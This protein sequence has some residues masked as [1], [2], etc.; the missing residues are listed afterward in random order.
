LNQRYLILDYET[1]S[2]ADLK[3]V[4]A[5]EYS[6]HPST[7]ILCAAW[8]IGTRE[9]LKN[10]LI[11]SWAPTRNPSGL[12]SL[13]H[14]LVNPEINLVAHN[15]LFEQVITRNVLRKYSPISIQINK[16]TP[17]NIPSER[18]ICT[19]AMA[20]AMALP[21][22]L[23]G[24]CQALNLP[25]QK[26]MEGRRLILKMCKPRK[27]TK[28][29]S[30]K[31]HESEEDL[32]RIIEYCKT[33]VEAETELFLAVPQLNPTERK[34]W[35]LDQKINLRGFQVDRKLINATLQMIEE[36]TKKLNKET[37]AMSFG[38]LGSTTQR[39]E[40]LKWLEA[41]KV[42][43][44][45]LR[46]K[47]VKDA[48]KTGLADGDAKRM[49]QIRQAVSKT[50]TAKYTAFEMRSR[51]DSRVR[52]ILV[53]HAATTGRWGGAGVQPQNFPRGNIKNTTQAAEILR[54]GDLELIRLLY[55][56]P[57]SAFSSCLRSVIKAPEG[58]EFFCADYNAIEA[59]VLFWV[60]KHAA[61]LKAFRDNRDL[62][63]EM[64]AVIHD[65]E[66]DE[67]NDLERFV[68][69]GVI[70]GCGYGMGWK[71]FVQTCASQGQI[72]QD[73]IAQKAIS[74]YRKVH[75]PVP[76][77]WSNLEKAA[78]AAV[79]NR[80]KKYTINRTSW[81][82]EGKFLFCELPSKRR[83]SYYGPEVR[84]VPTPW[85]E[86]RPVLYH[87]SVNS[88]TRKWELGKTWG[89]V[90]TENVVQ[91]IAR[92]LMA[93]AMLRIEDSGY[94]ISLSVHDELLAER[95]KE[96]G[97]V[98]EFEKLMAILPA[99]AEG[100]PVKVKGWVGPRYRK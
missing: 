96:K 39:N 56:D 2:E 30:A 20:S 6:K 71:K 5:W 44:P 59:R 41:E 100:C 32:R 1:R 97:S 4:G 31:W 94:Q 91:A 33:D 53:Y 45:D 82:V 85:D 11:Q 72:V 47:T 27:A 93:E 21:R 73:E 99:W 16:I 62:Y 18:W 67:I 28:K 87:W 13:L 40:V 46:A 95:E 37:E 50:S 36:E 24:A 7:E 89:G 83:L 68:G 66:Q 14:S 22:S 54:E 8:R 34:I 61:G 63:R 69:K 84:Y 98:E 58:R 35:V 78:I 10:A 80:G 17:N 74:L 92:D 48:L 86:K 77:L 42:F 81:W 70:L 23:E 49:L 25:V 90:L 52:D 19:A 88:V 12:V 26:D 3:K 75:H 65:K 9:E 29:N 57:M 55:G 43:L 79:L 60:A 38:T 76:T 64:A 51:T 15:A